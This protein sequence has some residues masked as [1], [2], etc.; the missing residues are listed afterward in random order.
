VGTY[1]GPIVGA[2]VYYPLKYFTQTKAAQLAL[3]ILGALIV[4]IVSFFPVGI[5]GG[6]RLKSKRLR[7]LLE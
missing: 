6:L 2:L 1:M 7:K 4:V 5:V 3:V